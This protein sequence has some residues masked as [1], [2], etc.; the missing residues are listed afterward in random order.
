M[1]VTTVN[2]EWQAGIGDPTFMGWLTV[3]A[4][5]TTFIISIICAIE[6]FRIPQEYKLH[7]HHWYWWG[8]ALIFLILGINKQLDLQTWFTITAKEIALMSGLYRDRRIF[9]GLFIG[10]LILGLLAFLTWLKKNT[11]VIL[12]EANLILYGLAFLS[13]FIIIRAISFY[14]F[15][16]LLHFRLAGLKINWIL[17]LGGISLVAFG[18]I[19]SLKKLH[20]IHLR[21]KSLNN[22]N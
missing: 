5:L 15:D 22:K 14:H 21:L 12:K 20:Q 4:Y 13:I 11:R 6:T 3:C 18:A 2:G 16:Q 7:Y 19:K 1:G 9:Q 10:C 8:L 17:E